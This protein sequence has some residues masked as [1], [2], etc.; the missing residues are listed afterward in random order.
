MS[1]QLQQQD[2]FDDVIGW[3]PRVSSLYRVVM[4]EGWLVGEEHY[5]ASEDEVWQILEKEYRIYRP[6]D[7]DE[8]LE[9]WN[10]LYQEGSL[11]WTDWYSMCYV[12]WWIPPTPKRTLDMIQQWADTH[13]ED[14]WLEDQT[15]TTQSVSAE[16][17]TGYIQ[18]L[19]ALLK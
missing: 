3:G 18:T 14:L 6:A 15:D 16:E 19:I 8:E 10:K 11:Y 2:E 1:E 4:F 5:G 9:L 12:D 7:P 17:L 13:I